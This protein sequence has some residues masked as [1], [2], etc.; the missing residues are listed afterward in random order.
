MTCTKQARSAPGKTS[1]RGPLGPTLLLHQDPLAP[2]RSP[3]LPLSLGPLSTHR[4]RPAQHMGASPCPN[5]QLKCLA[6]CCP[7]QF[8]LRFCPLSSLPWFMVKGPTF[9]LPSLVQNKLPGHTYV[10]K[11]RAFSLWGATSGS[12]LQAPSPR[13]GD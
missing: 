13:G 2:M 1:P 8:L 3:Y 10:S 11:C 5:T 4:P 12:L 7:G 6:H 9:C